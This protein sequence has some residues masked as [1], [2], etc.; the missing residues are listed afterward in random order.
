MSDG[1]RTVQFLFPRLPRNVR[2]RTSNTH[3]GVGRHYGLHKDNVTTVTALGT[4]PTVV[5]SRDVPAKA[6][7]LLNSP[8]GRNRGVLDSCTFP[9]PV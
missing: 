8:F 5:G 4:I 3:A 9:P 6:S 1:G 7:P 2:R